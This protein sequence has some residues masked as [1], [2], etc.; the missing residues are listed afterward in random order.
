MAEVEQWTKGTSDTNLLE[1]YEQVFSY[2]GIGRINALDQTKIISTTGSANTVVSYDYD[3]TYDKFNRLT[4]T[5]GSID[6]E[7]FNMS[8]TYNAAGGIKTKNQS[9]GTSN[10]Y[11]LSYGYHTSDKHQIDTVDGHKYTYNDAGSI[12]AIAPTSNPTVPSE[13][14]VWNEEEWLMVVE[15]SNGHHHY[16]YDQNGER[17]MKSTFTS[18]Q[19]AIDGEGNTNTSVLDPYAVYVNPYYIVTRYSVNQDVSKHYYMGSQRVATERLV[20]GESAGGTESESETGENLGIDASGSEQTTVANSLNNYSTIGENLAKNN[21]VTESLA[22]ILTNLGLEE[23]KDFDRKSM[24]QAPKMEEYF[25]LSMYGSTETGE[26]P[27]DENDYYYT[28]ERYWY[29]PNYL[30]N[31]DMITNDNGHIHQYF[32][33]SP[34]GENMYQYNRNSDFNSRYKFNGKELDEE[35]GNGYYGARYYNPKISVWLSVDP[36][37][38]KY[39]SSTPY[40]FVLNNPIHFVDPDGRVVIFVGGN[41]GFPTAACCGGTKKHWGEEW[42]ENVKKR[43]QDYNAI[44]YDGSVDDRGYGGDLGRKNFSPAF[45][46]KMGYQQGMKDAASIIENLNGASIKFVTSSM[47][48]AYARGMSQALTDY[49]AA[50]NVEVDKFNLTLEKNTDG[51]Y[52][53][54]SK[55]LEYLCIEIEFVVDLD[56]FQASEADVNAENNY[57]MKGDSFESK[58]LGTKDIK[59]STK[60]GTMKGHHPSWAPEENFPVGKNNGIGHSD[61]ENPSK[62]Q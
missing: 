6:G 46:Y 38:H 10:S 56:S 39:P 28:R 33:Y 29:H 48:T 59:G 3:Y 4:G 32:V 37:A 5:S 8:L 16:V 18:S 54:P 44:Y 22:K 47:G 2:D 7:T 1:T 52:K 58:A 27:D 34:F 25:D 12:V 9:L 51:T 20:W 14:F 21:P 36:L 42:V 11:N 60:I 57:Y 24:D 26:D 41:Y 15:N 40:N 61:V 62:N 23:N 53:D 49:V 45:R 19:T 17:I 35:T 30:G 13:E 31:V 43:I 50:F 55:V